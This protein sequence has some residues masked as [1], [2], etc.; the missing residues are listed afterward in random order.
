MNSLD[1]E[2]LYSDTDKTRK[3]IK[4]WLEQLSKDLPYGHFR[5]CTE[6]SLIPSIGQTCQAST[7]FAIKTA[8]QTGIWDEWPDIIKTGC[9]E[10]LR[11]V[12][13]E[14]GYFYDPWLHKATKFN[15]SFIINRILRKRNLKLCN[16]IAETRQSASTLLMIG[17][18]PVYPLPVPV[19]TP[20]EVVRYI[21]SLNWNNPWDA[22]SHFSHLIF[23]I[24]NNK[25]ISALSYNYQSLIHTAVKTL[26][27]YYHKPTG[28][29]FTGNPSNTQLVNGTMKIFTGLQLLGYKHPDPCNIIDFALSVPFGKDGCSFLDLI[30]VIYQARLSNP[31]YRSNDIKGIAVNALKHIN[32]FKKPDGGFSFYPDRAQTTYYR[33]RVSKGFPVSDLHG[34]VMATWI[35]SLCLSILNDD[36][37]S[38][39]RR[40]N[41]MIP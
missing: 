29:W 31:N 37:P 30:F 18:K 9:S 10:F 38:Q 25:K 3:S 6:G 13:Q 39:Y 41:I 17:K 20:D 2:N 28:T 15:L 19:K 33:A 34:T 22:G 7:C 23:F 16:L 32:G 36:Y 5:F 4:R 8:W 11:S 14:N 24:V 1:L 27:S 26:E 35:I 12:Q 21:T 40:W